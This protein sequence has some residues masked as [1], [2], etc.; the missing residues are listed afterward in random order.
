MY[1][2]I[3]AYLSSI[4]FF[5][6]PSPLDPES[7]C[8]AEDGTVYMPRDT[9]SPEPCTSC[10]CTESGGVQCSMKECP[11]LECESP[12]TAVEV[13]GGCCELCGDPSGKS[14]FY[15]AVLCCG[16]FVEIM[17]TFWHGLNNFFERGVTSL[18]NKIFH[19]KNLVYYKFIISKLLY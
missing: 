16:C 4:P 12:L 15:W 2:N 19:R 18:H 1:N 13:E 3:F 17:I 9:W 8:T 11:M 10:E 7:A 6:W 5:I 14:F